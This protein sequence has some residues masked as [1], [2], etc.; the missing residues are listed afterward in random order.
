MSMILPYTAVTRKP[1]VR[2]A[3]PSGSHEGLGL[4]AARR[5]R[6]RETIQRGI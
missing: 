1:A 5:N 3:R 6:S 2:K 4:K